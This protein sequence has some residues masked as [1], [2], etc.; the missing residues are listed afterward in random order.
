M[1]TGAR[2]GDWLSVDG[3]AHNRNGQIEAVYSA[4]GSPP[5]LVRWDDGREALLYWA[6][7]ET[8]LVPAVESKLAGRNGSPAPN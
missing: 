6:G 4:D 1:L 8:R 3:R 2:P 5:Y 7:P